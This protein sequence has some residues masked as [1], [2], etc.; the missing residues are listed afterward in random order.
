MRAVRRPAQHRQHDQNR[1]FGHPG[2]NIGRDQ[3][4]K[5]AARARRRTRARDENPS[6]A[7]P[8]AGCAPI[9][10]DTAMAMM[11]NSQQMPIT[12]QQQPDV[13]Q[14]AAARRCRRW[15]TAAA[16]NMRS[17]ENG[18]RRANTITQVEEIERERHH[19]QQRRRR[20]VGR[21]VRGD[22]D[23]QARRHGGERTPSA[24]CV[25]PARR[26][27]GRFA[28]PACAS[29]SRGRAA[30]DT[31]HH[32]ISRIKSDESRRST[33]VRLRAERG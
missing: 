5:Q 13:Q 11:K 23:Q 15:R 22:R 27:R 30:A 17:C 7:P 24:R 26:R 33:A 6:D 14:A 2:E 32:A 10:H 19:P 18:G 1:I 31:P 9:R 12:V 28:C 3:S 21:D 20:D 25:Q 29:V 4:G 8:P 16:V